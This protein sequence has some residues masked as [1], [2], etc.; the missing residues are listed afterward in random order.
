MG[1]IVSNKILYVRHRLG[2]GRAFAT[3][4]LILA[5]L[6]VSAHAQDAQ[7]VERTAKGS[8]AKPIRVGVYLNV[9]PDCS[10]GVLPTIRLLS[11]PANGTVEVKRGKVTATNYKQCLALEV[12]GY[13]A[14]YKSKTDFIG[15]DVVTLEVKYPNGRTEVQKISV[16]VGDGKGGRNI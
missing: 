6:G 8:T 12:P 5:G 7:T 11:P 16:T 14:F 2:I 1:T 4:V 10:S 9:Q 15:V 3:G 13:V